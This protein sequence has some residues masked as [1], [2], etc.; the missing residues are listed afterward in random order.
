VS[1][2]VDLVCRVILNPGDEVILPEPNYVCYSPLI[3]LAGG[4]PVCLDT[5]K[6]GFIPDLEDLTALITDKTKAIIL[7]SPNNPTGA[8]IPQETQDGL[9]SLAQK[10]G[11]WL[12]ADEIYAEL[13]YEK[14]YRSFSAV[15]GAKDHTILL[16]GF[17]KAFAMTGW[18]LGYIAGPEDLVSRCLKIHQYSALCAPIIS[19]LAAEAAFDSKSDLIRMRDSYKQRRNLFKTRILDMG[20]DMVNPDGAFYAF[21][22]IRSLE[23]SSED[24]AIRL[25]KSQ[26]VAV[27]PGH[28][29]GLG[30]EGFVRCCYATAMDDL[31][32]ALDKI[33]KFVKELRR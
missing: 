23:L 10:H 17:S 28:V 13:S 29:F 1:E 25:L 12:I 9:V 20:L 6:T 8:I 5:S 26:G 21:V 16:S 15:K 31:I 4:V 24:F 30:G 19:Q 33:E 2:A 18:R 22:D 3:R 7:C 32:K 14:E 11:F 27:V